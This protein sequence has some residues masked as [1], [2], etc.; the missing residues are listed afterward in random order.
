MSVARKIA[1]KLLPHHGNPKLTSP[2]GKIPIG[3][4]KP[5]LVKSK[6]RSGTHLLIDLILNNFPQL[7]TESL[8]VELDHAY[9]QSISADK[10]SNLG[11]CL[12][13][14]HYGGKNGQK[15]RE[16]ITQAV[17]QR[18]YI[19]EPARD[20]EQMKSSLQNFLN[21]EGY[22]DY[23]DTCKKFDKYWQDADCLQIPFEDLICKKGN[24]RA[25]KAIAKYIGEQPSKKLYYNRSKNEA[26]KIL[27]EKLLTR[28]RGT[29]QRRVNTTIQF[30]ENQH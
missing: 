5:V 22:Q 14:T 23:L 11:K 2:P 13:K 25:V 6:M 30:N 27:V 3:E 18:A 1:S 19:I 8:Y 4:G 21:E 10:F 7:R 17:A 24:D 28:I 20:L 9:H 26:K 16:D 12:C 29:N 15:L